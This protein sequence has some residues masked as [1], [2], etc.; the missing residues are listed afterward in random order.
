MR[1]TQDPSLGA[2]NLS[3]EVVLQQITAHTKK[4]FAFN[5]AGDYSTTGCMKEK[6]TRNTNHTFRAA[7]LI[8]RFLACLPDLTTEGE[9]SKSG[10]LGAQAP[11]LSRTHFIGL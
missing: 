1:W 10:F 7:W 2:N 8:A 6:T 9:A 3:G 4:C 5:F 11:D